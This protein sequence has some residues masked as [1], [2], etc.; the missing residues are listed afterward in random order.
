[1]E[2]QS[3][4]STDERFR[5]DARFLEEDEEKEEKG[6]LLFV[7]NVFIFFVKLDNELLVPT[8]K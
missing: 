3:R 1:M 6:E 4:F 5:M 7:T 2:L 8:P